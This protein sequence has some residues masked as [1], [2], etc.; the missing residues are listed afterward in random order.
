MRGLVESARLL[1]APVIPEL[2]HLPFQWGK[3]RQGVEGNS[4]GFFEQALS[5]SQ[6]TWGKKK[7]TRDL[8]PFTTETS[9]P[10][11]KPQLATESL[12]ALRSRPEREP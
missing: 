9:Q 8:H 7:K 4:N 11:P 3:E 10:H 2:L 1:Q 5:E 6:G 12:L